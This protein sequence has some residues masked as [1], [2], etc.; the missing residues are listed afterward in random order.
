MIPP[1]APNGEFVGQVRLFPQF[2]I[3][4]DAAFR[5]DN[6]SHDPIIRD[7][8]F[9]TSEPSLNTA[10]NF[11]DSITK[12]VKCLKLEVFNM[13]ITKAIEILGKEYGFSA[14]DTDKVIKELQLPKNAQILEVGTGMGSLSITLAL[15][16]YKVVTGEPSD[17]DTIYA[18][19]NWRQNAKKVKVDHL[20]EFQSFNANDIP[21][22]DNTF[23]A[24]FCQGT[25]HH[26]EESE[27]IKV[28]QEFIRA[29][30][31]NAI[32]CF[33]EPNQKSIKMIRQS[34]AS[35]PDAA[36]PNRYITD[37]NLI[38]KKIEGLNFDAFIL[39]RH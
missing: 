29:A 10:N 17:D 1:D 34:D 23:D 25:L 24:I 2:E 26:I 15:N 20:I 27:R 35:H 3:M 9:T 7:L 18:N 12:D 28:F 6:H 30:K 22:D 16:G 5:I 14:V 11:V 19:Q 33:F 13:R 4:G 38:S 32:I 36:D 21:Y 37:D 31:S 39:Q 8:T